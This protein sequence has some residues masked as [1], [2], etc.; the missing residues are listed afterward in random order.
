MV[1]HCN[2]TSIYLA[3]TSDLGNN[4][5]ALEFFFLVNG[6]TAWQSGVTL[7]FLFLFFIFACSCSGGF[8]RF[9]FS[10]DGGLLFFFNGLLFLFCFGSCAFA[11][12]ID[13][14]RIYFM[15]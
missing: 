13:C 15:R 2:G 6:G 14:F 9:F 1:T 4:C 5:F 12:T 7:A 11:P 8:Y 3:K 10:L